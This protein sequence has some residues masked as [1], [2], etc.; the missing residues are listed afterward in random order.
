MLRSPS[1]PCRTSPEPGYPCI[2]SARRCNT[3]ARPATGAESFGI[4]LL[5]AL[6]SGLPVAAFPVPGPNDVVGGTRVGVLDPDL[7]VAALAALR[8]SRAECRAEALRCGWDVSAR[9]FFGNIVE[10]HGGARSTRDAA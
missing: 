6:A 4:V 7:R 5:E 3:V 9:Q 8:L 10:A 1:H 2:A